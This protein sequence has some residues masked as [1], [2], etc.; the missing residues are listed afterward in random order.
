[1]L[2]QIAVDFN[3]PDANDKVLSQN[4]FEIIISPQLRD[5][6][7]SWFYWAFRA[8]GKVGQKVRFI[9]QLES[10]PNYPLLSWRLTKVE[11]ENL[12]QDAL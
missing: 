1:M 10:D 9:L 12:R 11:T 2:S 8:R 3:F 7:G 6:S 5:T 4:E